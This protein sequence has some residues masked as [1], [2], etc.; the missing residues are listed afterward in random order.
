LVGA[1]DRKGTIAV[2]HPFPKGFE[3]TH[4]VNNDQEAEA[5]KNGSTK[6]QARGTKTETTDELADV[7]HQVAAQNGIQHP[8]NVDA[9][10]QKTNGETRTIYTTTYYIGLELKPLE[11][12]ASRSLD[13]STDAQIFK[14]TCTSWAGFQPGINDLSIIHVRNFDLPDDVFEPGDTRPTRPK[15]KIVKK[16]EATA[17]KRNIDSLEG[18]PHGDAKRQVTS[19]GIQSQATPA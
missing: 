10:E 7:N 12:G 6:Y 2:S 18:V 4:T 11:P 19:N 3:R 1:L 5:V 15:K 17:Q 9:G 14:S 8:E 16:T 13:I